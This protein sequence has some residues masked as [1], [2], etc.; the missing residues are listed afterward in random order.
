MTAL[1]LTLPGQQPEWAPSVAL[2]PPERFQLQLH[3]EWEC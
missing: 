2:G 1:G 3:R